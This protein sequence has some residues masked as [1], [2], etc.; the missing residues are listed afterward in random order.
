MFIQRISA[1]YFRKQAFGYAG[2]S[3]ENSLAQKLGIQQFPS[4]LLMENENL[5][6]RIDDMYPGFEIVKPRRNIYRFMT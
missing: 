5:L 2:G 1:K 6:W 4:I 3:S